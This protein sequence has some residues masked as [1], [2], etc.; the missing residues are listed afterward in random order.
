VQI[1]IK[2]KIPFMK[3]RWFFAAV[4]IAAIIASLT[5][6]YFNGFN[7]GIDFRGGVKLTVKF[8]EATSDGAIKDALKKHNVDAIVQ[9]LGSEEGEKFTIKT[10]QGEVSLEEKSSK[11]TSALDDSFGKDGYTIEAEETV[12]PKVGEE[13]RKKGQLAILFTLIAILIYL[14]IR[15]NFNYAPGAIVALAHDV[16]ITL[17]IL[18]LL[19]V[20]FNLTILAALLTIV[21]YS[22]NDTIVVF[23]RIRENSKRISGSTL[24]DVVNDSL[25]TTLSRTIITSVTTL[26]VVIILFF[27]GGGVIHD[28]A[29]TFIVG[30]L[31]GT[32]S[33]IFVASPTFIFMY[34]H[35]PKLAVKIGL[36]KEV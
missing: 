32:Y 2:K 17:G 12:G 27:F 11:I 33:S 6:I 34:R 13:L 36:R 30:I 9:R 15:F 26:I 22:V 16:T 5:S 3:F 29:L 28:F 35:W 24:I 31:V 25:N 18:T 7:Y 14:S 20:E 19:G 21:G 23:D 4:S 10:K 8:K 1:K